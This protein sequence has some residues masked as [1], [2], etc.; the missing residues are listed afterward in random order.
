MDKLF[1][2]IRDLVA[3]LYDVLSDA[4]HKVWA[5]VK[6]IFLIGMVFDLATGNLGWINQIL[7]YYRDLLAYTSGASWLVIVF[8]ALL[9]FHGMTKKR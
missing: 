1:D 8:G 3:S 4:A 7:G 6:P 5:L 9:L 2:P